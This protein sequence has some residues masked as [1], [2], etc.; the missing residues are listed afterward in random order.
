MDCREPA[1]NVKSIKLVIYIFRESIRQQN[2]MVDRNEGLPVKPLLRQ[3]KIDEASL[4][5]EC[6]EGRVNQ[7]EILGEIDKM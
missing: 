6:S 4:R 5:R 1:E 2:S 7:A 3:S